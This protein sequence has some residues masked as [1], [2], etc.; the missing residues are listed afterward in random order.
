M[1]HKGLKLLFILDLDDWLNWQKLLIVF[2]A[3]ICQKQCLS[4][5]D[6]SQA[7]SECSS[8]IVSLFWFG[9]KSIFHLFVQYSEGWS[10]ASLIYLSIIDRVY[11]DKNI[12]YRFLTTCSR[13]LADQMIEC[14]ATSKPG[15]HSTPASSSAKFCRS[16]HS[17]STSSQLFSSL[18]F[19]FSII[20]LGR[21]GTKHC[22]G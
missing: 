18:Y 14:P 15:Q 5:L 6:A 22:Q 19:L 1:V 21:V 13:Y 7:L 17:L 11:Q 9:S 3:A 2:C 4:C 12:Y 20:D 8:I 16:L 10:Q